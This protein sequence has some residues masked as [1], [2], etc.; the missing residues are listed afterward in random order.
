MIFNQKATGLAVLLL[1][2]LLVGC[3]GQDE[4]SSESGLIVHMAER[5]QEESAQ[6]RASVASAIGGYDKSNIA[7][8][9]LLDGGGHRLAVYRAYL[10]L[11][12][13][14][15]VPC[16]SL[17]QWPGRIL[18][19]LV[20]TAQAHAGHGSEPVGGRALDKPN[21]IDLLTQDGFALPLGN[22]AIAPGRYC[23][24]QLT[25]ARLASD[26]YGKPEFT[27]A[28]EDDPIS[29]PEVP[30]LTG[31]IF[32]FRM[33]YCDTL[34]E[35]SH[36]LHRTRLDIDDNG[37]ITPATVTLDFSSPL[38]LNAQHRE[39]FVV[40]GI[41]YGQWFKGMDVTQMNSDSSILPTLL[42]NIADSLT[43]YHKGLGELP[44]NVTGE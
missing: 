25:L 4:N 35:E 11:D 42:E 9:D 22:L 24:I 28:S 19:G 23:G 17:A 27:P 10:L 26:A 18:G 15:L 14:Q 34:D 5:H 16:T 3:P 20:S 7:H 1:L 32:S 8:H 13:L 40:I 29:V 12:D 43:V 38:E 30:D 21:V 37:Q 41:S 2:G 33:D 31:K 36:C 39:G 44:A 6:A